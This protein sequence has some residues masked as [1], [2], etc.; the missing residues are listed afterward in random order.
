MEGCFYQ[1]RR[2]DGMLADVLTNKAKGAKGFNAMITAIM[3]WSRAT[4]II[5]PELRKMKKKRCK[6]SP[7]QMKITTQ[8]CVVECRHQ[9]LGRYEHIRM[10]R[11]LR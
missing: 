8:A 7:N 3:S 5:A 9:K 4:G 10:S 2:N 6:S 1:N 11:C